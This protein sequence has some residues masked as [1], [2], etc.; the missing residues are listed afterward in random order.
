M[1]RLRLIPSN[2]ADS[3]TVTASSTAGSY[4]AANLQNST[5]T[6]KWR[7]T[8]TSAT[9]TVT[10]AAPQTLDSIALMRGNLTSAATW[11]IK[12]YDATPTLLYDSTA[13]TASPSSWRD[14]QSVLWLDQSYAVKSMTIELADATNSAGYVEASR[15]VAGLGWSPKYEPSYGAAL[16]I[17]SADVSGR[18][19]DGTLRSERRALSRAM[20]FNLDVLDESDR[21]ALIAI[22]ADLGQS[23][24]FLVSLAAGAASPDQEHQHTMMGKF[25]NNVAA[26]LA[27]YGIAAAQ[28][29]IA[30]A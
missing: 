26:A 20:A 4:A 16:T 3:A 24:D 30:E 8:G 21:A 15:L 29:Q 18:A 17:D 12:L 7:A 19:E 27:H 13:I 5:R 25:S 28:V 9:L 1:P 6:A 11:R 10:F 14:S 23:V 22:A 2:L